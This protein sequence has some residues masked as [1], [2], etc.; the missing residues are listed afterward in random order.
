[1][2][3]QG[4]PLAQPQGILFDSLGRNRQEII[5]HEKNSKIHND[6]VNAMKTSQR[7]MREDL[8]H[9]IDQNIRAENAISCRVFSAVYFGIKNMG[10]SLGGLEDLVDM[11]KRRYNV[12]LGQGCSSRR[13]LTHI[14]HSIN[15][16]MKNRLNTHIANSDDPIVVLFDGSTA[17]GLF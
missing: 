9:Y 10:S 14:L 4:T 13:T 15:K 17:R 1:M 5:N 6:L 2:L 3:L 8:H 7:I 11:A 12:E 16:S